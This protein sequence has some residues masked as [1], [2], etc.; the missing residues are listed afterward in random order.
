MTNNTR[1]SQITR[2]GD[3][4]NY[5]G[6]NKSSTSQDVYIRELD[7]D[8][9]EPTTAH[10]HSTE[11]G[12]SK[13]VVIGKPGSGKSVLI[14]SIFYAK[15]HIFPCGIFM[16]G[17]EDSN[18]TYKSR[19]PSIFVYNDY[20]ADVIK[21]WIR[22]QKIAKQHLPVPWSILLVDDCTDDPRI[23]NQPLQQGLYKRGRHWASL[24]VLSLQHSMDIKPVIRT[25]I[26][27]TF[28]LR[29]P[30]LK[31]RKSL[32][33]NYASII[34]DFALFCQIMDK[35]TDDYT[36]LYI[37]NRSTSNV[38]TDCVFYYKAT[39]PPK[40]WKFGCADYQNFHKARYNPAY[41]EPFD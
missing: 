28:I 9:I 8:M 5:P 29:E 17:T 23:F 40:D 38:W 33:E 25:N 19:A 6:E 31:T 41:T 15:K 27:G 18:H 4:W 22:R 2:Y 14:M 1:A 37:N 35:I 34:P 39:V 26:D 20:E 13:L 30:I 16:S 11:L 32:W 10:M 24:Y 21:D 36:A 12:G 7:I 3:K